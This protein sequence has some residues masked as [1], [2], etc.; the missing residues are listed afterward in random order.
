MKKGPSSKSVYKEIIFLMFYYYLFNS[1]CNFFLA[2]YLF[3]YELLKTKNHVPLGK[4]CMLGWLK[5]KINVNILMMNS[6]PPTLGT[7]FLIAENNRT[8]ESPLTATFWPRLHSFLCFS[9]KQQTSTIAAQF[10]NSSA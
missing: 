7:S 3:Q 5:I 10:G 1:Q 2:F 9:F 8:H 6:Q 4:N